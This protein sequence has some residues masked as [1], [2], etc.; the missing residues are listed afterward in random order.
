MIQGPLFYCAS[1]SILSLLQIQAD[2]RRDQTESP[3]IKIA[4]ILPLDWLSP[5]LP[6]AWNDLPVKVVKQL[7]E[8]VCQLSM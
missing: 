5:S 4:S 2:T 7:F 8:G 6:K 3:L 1:F